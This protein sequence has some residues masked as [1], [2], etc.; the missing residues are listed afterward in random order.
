VPDDSEDFEEGQ[1]GNDDSLD[2][3]FDAAE[4]ED[5]LPGEEDKFDMEAYLK[6]RA[7]NPD[8]VTTGGA[9]ADPGAELSEE[10]GDD[11]SYDEQDD[12]GDEED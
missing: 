6:W 8:D 10:D 3:D 12:Y 4:D 7:E 9:L 1:E 5:E 2:D 11:A